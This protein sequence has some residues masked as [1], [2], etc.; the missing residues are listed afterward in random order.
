MPR[1]P[2]GLVSLRG[3]A[4]VRSPGRLGIDQR[5]SPDAV[6]LHGGMD[7]VHGALNLFRSLGDLRIAMERHRIDRALAT[8]SQ[9]CPEPGASAEAGISGAFDLGF[10]VTR[11]A[12]AQNDGFRINGL[13]NTFRVC[14][15]GYQHLRISIPEGTNVGFVPDL[16]I[17][18]CTGSDV[19]DQLGE[20]CI[21]SAYV[22]RL[23][24]A[25]DW[26][27]GATANRAGLSEGKGLA[28]RRPGQIELAI[29]GTVGNTGHRDLFL[30]SRVLQG[31]VV[32]AVGHGRGNCNDAASP[33]NGSD[34]NIGGQCPGRHAAKAVKNLR[35]VGVREVDLLIEALPVI[36]AGCR[37]KLSPICSGVPEPY[38]AQRH[39]RPRGATLKVV[40]IHA[41][42][43]RRG[44][45]R[46]DRRWRLSDGV[47]GGCR[48]ADRPVWVDG[49]G[50]HL[51]AAPNRDWR[52][53]V[54]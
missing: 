20:V 27:V 41:K 51:H 13:D 32:K 4:V 40:D 7:Q 48:R 10:V 29:E 15:H 33:L 12:G 23:L 42:E 35:R 19:R 3:K 30:R 53:I 1:K 47:N 46:L 44:V 11:V 6:L 54:G 8:Q 36:G 39:A 52:H 25:G 16:P 22:R 5:Q 21:P 49:D 37:V 38:R 14:R 9:P 17:L 18:D 2:C 26:R 50:S 34:W 28:V 43:G 24:R 31:A 45:G